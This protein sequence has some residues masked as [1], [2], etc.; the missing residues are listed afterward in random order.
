MVK[1]EFK[2]NEK[3]AATDSTEVNMTEKPDQQEP[4]ETPSPRSADLDFD[5]QSPIILDVESQGP[6]IHSPPKTMDWR[7][8]R[9]ITMAQMTMAMIA[10]IAI[11]IA[12]F[13]SELNRMLVWYKTAMFIWVL[14]LLTTA[15]CGYKSGPKN[16]TQAVAYFIMSIFQ[17]MLN[18]VWMAGV[19]LA[20]CYTLV[21]RT[22]D[23]RDMEWSNKWREGLLVVEL[24]ENLCLLGTVFTG[25]MGAVTG[26]RGFGRILQFQDETIQARYAETV[27]Y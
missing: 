10:M 22:R 7:Q 20:V 1:L 23:Y 6:K 13:A 2:L 9:R 8:I 25:L 11:M 19:F 17:T 3:P 16:Y 14:Y 26:C 12:V 27:R 24:V 18:G 21:A 4:P 5:L 15:Y